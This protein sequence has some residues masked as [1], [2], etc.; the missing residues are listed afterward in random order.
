[1]AGP[2]TWRSLQPSADAQTA[3]NLLAAS[4]RSING[5]FDPFQKIIQQQEA[6][7]SEQAGMVREGNKQAFLDALSQAK[8]PE[9]LATLQGSGQLQTLQARLTA[10]DRGAVRG[11]DEARL[12]GLRQQV[13]A[14]QQFDENQVLF[15]QRQAEDQAAQLIAM[16]TPE[17]RAQAQ[18]I[19]NTDLT[20]NRAKFQ[21][22]MSAAAVA[23]TERDR[24]TTKFGWDGQEEGRKA[25]KAKREAEA[26]TV[27]NTY[28]TTLTAASE[29]A[30]VASVS[31]QEVAK[32]QLAAAAANAK[33]EAQ[34]KFLKESGN[35]YSD[36]VFNPND[37]QT[38]NEM[39][40]KNGIGDS[41]GERQ[42]IIRRLQQMGGEV[43][44]QYVDGNNKLATKKVP[45][46]MSL[47]KSSILGSSDQTMN[48]WN[49]GWANE[50]EANLKKS[51]RQVGEKQL[52]DG[53]VYKQNSTVF[54]FDQ[55]MQ[56]RMQAAE[57]PAVSGGKKK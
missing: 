51:M 56:T 9:D 24:A 40:V 19:I 25:A 12:A 16:N 20:R 23:A 42:A 46:P 55:Y 44:L 29:A 52:P 33:A 41:P 53:R 3:A 4:Q 43:E 21:S 13:T 49:E 48:W 32:Q 45:I 27:D 11:A 47:V 15:N 31:Q 22:A 5:A 8:T 50:M 18:E 57:N 14:G 28:K 37:T 26:A 54:D 17:A 10:Q 36:G 6:F 1:M 35:V 34:T 38:L 2:I 39:M 7:A 30:R